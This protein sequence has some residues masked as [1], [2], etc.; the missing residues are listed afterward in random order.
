MKN[1]SNNRRRFD[2]DGW[3]E[4]TMLTALYGLGFFGYN[5]ALYI[6]VILYIPSR[7]VT[8]PHRAIM[9]GV[10]SLSIFYML[11]RGRRC[12]RGKLWIPLLVFWVLYGCR[13][14]IESM[15][16]GMMAHPLNY[17]M[18]YAYGVCGVPM[19][20]FMLRYSEGGIR[21]AFWV[22]QACAMGCVIMTLALYGFASGGRAVGGTFIGDFVAIGPLILSYM[23]SAVVVLGFYALLYPQNFRNVPRLLEFLILGVWALIP[24]ESL[25]ARLLQYTCALSLLLGGAYMLAMGASRGPVIAVFGCGIFI[26][27]AKMR[28][29]VDVFKVI[30]VF[31]CLGL[32]G[33]VG[34]Y[35][36]NLMGSALA[37][38]L[39][40]LTEVFDIIKYGGFGV[41]RVFMWQSAIAQ[42]LESPLLG[43]GLIL[44]DYGTY[45]HNAILEAFMTTGIFGGIAFL[46]FLVGCLIKA[47]QLLKYAPEHGWVAVLFVHYVIYVQLS[48]SIGINNYFWYGAAGVLGLSQMMQDQV[49]T[50]RRRLG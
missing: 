36:S 3:I 33:G 35:I 43:N 37:Q 31:I 26:G 6:A 2:W 20:C 18:L 4:K 44:S 27:L 41:E 25:R 12:Y 7:L 50:G 46:T 13:I 28:E 22:M 32:L 24:G 34:L 9:L 45:P 49:Y 17:Y 14:L 19:V 1:F 47:Y 15:T 40:E 42:F 23:G 5:V 10:A 30:F 21:F 38:R 11:F 48:S 39:M 16:G 29:P 8:M